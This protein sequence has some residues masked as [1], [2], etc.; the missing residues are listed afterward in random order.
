MVRRV[1]EINDLGFA[2]DYDCLRFGS[3]D[4]RSFLSEVGDL[5]R[6]TNRCHHIVICSSHIDSAVPHCV[7]PTDKF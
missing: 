1:V 3:K 5:V 7:P 4:W 6:L 2:S